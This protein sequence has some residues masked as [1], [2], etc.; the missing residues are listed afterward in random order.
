VF[1]KP[2][3]T[4]QFVLFG[5]ESGTDGTPTGGVVITAN[6]LQ[7]RALDAAAKQCPEEAKKLRC[8]Y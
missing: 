1:K 2:G 6:K 8:C 3:D 5:P 7:K 4:R